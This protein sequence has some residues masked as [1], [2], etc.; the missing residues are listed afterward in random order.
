MSTPKAYLLLLCLLVH[1]GTATYAREKLPPVE[2]GIKILSSSNDPEGKSYYRIFDSLK[3]CDSSAIFD[4]LNQVESRGKFANAYFRARLSCI[5]MTWKLQ[6]RQYQGK[7]EMIQLCETAMNYAYETGDDAF[8]AF[9]AIKCG[10]NS[11]HLQE[12]ELAATYLLKGQELYEKFDP[13]VR[14]QS[15]NWIVV[16]EVL[17]HCQE[18]EKSIF[19]TRKAIE[20]FED[21]SEVNFL[22]RFY[23]T[24]GQ[25]FDRLDQEDS[26]MLYYEKSMQVAKGPTIEV[27]KGINA[28]YIGEIYF[29]R[30]QYSKAKPLLEYNYTINRT[31]EFDHAAKSLQVLAA[32]DLAQG[33][34]DSALVK[35]REALQ[36]I[37]KSGSGFYLQPLFFLERIYFTASDVYRALGNTDSFYVYNDLYSNLHDS[38]QK[39]SL[40]ISAKIAKLRIDNDNNLRSVQMLENEKQAA[41]LKR[42]FIL[43]TIMLASA[44]L[45]LYL[46][47]LRLKQKHRQEI[48]MQQKNAAEAELSAA[49]EQMQLITE[50]IIEKTGLIEKLTAQ[51]SNKELNTEQHQLAADI[52]RQT[53]LTEEQWENFKVV[54]EKIHPGFFI[55]LKEKARDI[56][57]AEQRMAA[58]TRLNLTSRQMASMLGISVDSVHK[59]R[60]RLRQRLQYSNEKNLEESLS[61]L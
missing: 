6:Y 37:K 41:S 49:K 7:S 31:R 28:G 13:P 18:Y 52:S 57:L 2:E 42:N 10:T 9:I 27:W 29:R 48:V 20:H 30:K 32:I 55:R 25:D 5:K 61:S 1:S 34:N 22:S 4:F 50:N 51:L 3:L 36:L 58:L 15:A 16:G 35:I 19:Y 44:I 24:I 21:T 17:F 47:R 40:L 43:L 46:N 33:R 60:Q 14:Q 53:I 8:I 38:L 45:I 12:L 11:L 23:N 54:F 56:T 59:T 26:A 39:V